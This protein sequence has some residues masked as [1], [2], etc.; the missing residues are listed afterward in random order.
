M[1]NKVLIFCFGVFVLLTSCGTNK[2][3]EN[4]TDSEGEISRVE[5]L[6]EVS[7]SAQPKT[8]KRVS[9]TKY[10]D[11]IHTQLNLTPNIRKNEVYGKAMIWLTPH[12]YESTSTIS[13]DAKYLNISEVSVCNNSIKYEFQNPESPTLISDYT[14]SPYKLNINLPKSYVHGDTLCLRIVYFV[15]PDSVP[16]GGGSIAIRE[17]QGIYMLHPDSLHRKRPK[18]LWT[19]GEPESAS[20]WFPTLDAP[21]QKST[22]V[23]RVNF[24]EDMMSLSNGI[25]VSSS[26]DGDVKT[27][28]WVNNL[29]ISP[30][31]FTLVLGDFYADSTSSYKSIPLSYMVDPEYGTFARINYDHTPEM[32]EYFSQLTGVPF[33]WQKYSQVLVHDFVSGAMENTSAVTFGHFI[34]KNDRELLDAPN[35]AIVAHELF[36]HWFGD[37]VTFES[38]NHISL[39]ESFAT[40]GSLLWHG[41]KDGKEMEA[42]ERHKM[43]G[44][45]LRSARADEPPLLREYYR[46]PGEVFDRIS[47]QK[48]ASVLYMLR[49]EIGERNF[50]SAMNHFLETHAYANAEIED[51]RHSLEY[52]TGVDMTQFFR[53]WYYTPGLPRLRVKISDDEENQKRLLSIS[54]ADSSA[55]YD[56]HPALKYS[57]SQ[58]DSFMTVSVVDSIQTWDFDYIE[59]V[60]PHLVLDPDHTLAASIQYFCPEEYWKK[61]LSGSPKYDDLVEALKYLPDSE[62]RDVQMDLAKIVV[63]NKPGLS[64]LAAQYV[65]PATLSSPLYKKPV[66][67][68]IANNKNNPSLRAKLIQRMAKVS[69]PDKEVWLKS[70]CSDTSYSVCASSLQEIDSIDHDFAMMYVT[71]S[72]KHVH[73]DLYEMCLKL[74]S[75]QDSSYYLSFLT[76]E[77][78]ENY[79]RDCYKPAFYLNKALLNVNTEE[80]FQKG[81]DILIQKASND[82]LQDLDEYILKQLYNTYLDLSKKEEKS[83]AEYIRNKIENELYKSWDR[84]ERVEDLQEIYNWQVKF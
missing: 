23:I 48:G 25:K 16:S 5:A 49:Q 26:Q 31:L 80:E 6:P 60:P 22:Q 42:Y 65:L 84:P 4:T 69:L 82:D 38:W 36:H 58:G 67:E 29:R 24:S 37:L 13:I 30:Y 46:K 12:T 19:Q 40:L 28:T 74:L 72:V 51:W 73:G 34:Q 7:V 61:T 33:P 35:D 27:D 71:D 43:L 68:I 20:F 62:N 47:Y 52:V 45:Y 83:K 53:Q 59:G 41:Y 32:I 39:S 44:R 76:D 11:L 8:V 75:A 70:L 57:T 10:W 66:L 50:D 2:P 3:I 14:K 64:L 54:Y 21:N 77:T 79:G 17:R 56:L 18:Q 1:S 63:K 81:V 55:L 15:T 9:A 78:Q